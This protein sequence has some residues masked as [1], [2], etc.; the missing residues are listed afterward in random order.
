M[1]P[2]NGEFLRCRQS[3]SLY[4][5]DTAFESTLAAAS[6]QISYTSVPGNFAAAS[7][8]PADWG[9]AVWMFLTGIDVD[10]PQGRGAIVALGSSSTGGSGPG[11]SAGARWP[12]VLARRL[13][14]SPDGAGMSVLTATI[15]GNQ[16]LANHRTPPTLGRFSRDVLGQPG[17][18]HVIVL[19]GVND[20]TMGAINPREPVTATDVIFALTQIATRAHDHGL[21]AIVG[22]LPPFEGA[23]YD[24]PAL[25]YGPE[26]EA[27][28]RK[29]NTWIRSNTVFE[30][31]IDF[32]A[33]V[34]DAANPTR[35]RASFDQGDHIHVNDSG[36]RA[37]G[38]CVD[39]RLF[40][41]AH[42][43]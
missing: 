27:I 21:A 2:L 38:E 3:Q 10:N 7:A 43:R 34:R 42:R 16:L 29:V 17:V 28:R 41:S 8:F 30:G 22:T 39:L 11:I 36:F 31:V 5:P 13:H 25:S 32:D 19:E 18:T 33:C 23:T 24:T 4:L 6:P 14:A 37:M 9:R 35:L 26:A 12:D 40:T 20:I 1:I 15:N